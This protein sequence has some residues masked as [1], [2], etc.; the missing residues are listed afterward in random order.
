MKNL[1]AGS[2]LL[3][4]ARETLLTELMPLAKSERAKYHLLMVAN[5]MGIAARELEVGDAAEVA[6]LAR[7]DRLYGQPS[8]ELH[9]NALSEALAEYERVLTHDIRA[10]RFDTEDDR[11]RALLDHLEESVRARLRISNP[12]SLST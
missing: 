12:K 7:L 1:P 5:A 6:A 9:G 8:R 2:D 4:I 10:G 3:A 11:R